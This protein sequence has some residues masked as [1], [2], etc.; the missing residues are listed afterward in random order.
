MTRHDE[1]PLIAPRCGSWAA[2]GAA[3]SHDQLCAGNDGCRRLPEALP[4]RMC[5]SY[6]ANSLFDVV[7]TLGM[8]SSSPPSLR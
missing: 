3:G 2:L 5:V 6:T 1:E 7:G 4:D 8:T